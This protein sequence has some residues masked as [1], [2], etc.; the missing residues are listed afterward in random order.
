MVPGAL[1]PKGGR[2]PPGR[3]KIELPKIMKPGWK[4]MGL[5]AGPFFWKK[6]CKMVYLRHL[7]GF[8]EVGRGRGNAEML[9]GGRGR[10][11]VRNLPLPWGLRKQKQV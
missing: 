4:K 7:G 2:T 10:G 6:K 3:A 1:P 8:L 9:N 5:R 11:T